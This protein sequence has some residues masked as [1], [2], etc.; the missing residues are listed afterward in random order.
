MTVKIPDSLP[1][2]DNGREIVAG[3]DSLLGGEDINGEYRAYIVH[4]AN[5]YPALVEALRVMTATF[6]PFSS[7]PV[8]APGSPARMGQEAQIAAHAKARAALKAAGVE[9]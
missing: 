9:P 8:G 4:A 6:L 1:W 5:A 7:R 3:D 2:R